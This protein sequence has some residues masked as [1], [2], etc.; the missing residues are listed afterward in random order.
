MNKPMYPALSE[1]SVLNLRNLADYYY[2]LSVYY[3]RTGNEHAAKE[4]HA[5]S[6]HNE[7]AF[8]SATKQH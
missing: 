1:V 2:D 4:A 5:N 7:Y 3:T 6:V 8:L